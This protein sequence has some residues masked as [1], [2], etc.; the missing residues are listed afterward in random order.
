MSRP[1]PIKRNL[2]KK[3]N[4][5]DSDNDDSDSETPKKKLN[6]EHKFQVKWLNDTRFSA[7]ISPSKQCLSKAYC[8][9]CECEVSGSVTL[10][11]RHGNTEKHKK[12][13]LSKNQSKKVTSFFFIRVLVRLQNLKSKWRLQN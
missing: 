12:N 1:R 4:D 10:L 8:I 2:L 3:T 5:S 7:W 11:E 13:L 6:Y 9:A